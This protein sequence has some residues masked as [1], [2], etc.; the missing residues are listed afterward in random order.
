MCRRRICFST[1]SWRAFA[2]GS[3]ASNAFGPESGS[4][5]MKLGGNGCRRVLF[6]GSGLEDVTDLVEGEITFF[7]AV[8]EVGRKAHAGFW[9]VV[10]QDIACKEL[11]ADFVG[12]RTVEGDGT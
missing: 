3:E 5:G 11:A 12:V 6:P 2:K 9:P 7:E 1:I 8:V 10:D 4:S